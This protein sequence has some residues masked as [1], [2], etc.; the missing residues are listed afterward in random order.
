MGEGTAGLN[1]MK[2]HQ[3][4]QDF[5]LLYRLIDQWGTRMISAIRLVLGAGGGR[6]GLLEQQTFL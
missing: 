4:L 5:G 1:E 2:R 3:L 6:S